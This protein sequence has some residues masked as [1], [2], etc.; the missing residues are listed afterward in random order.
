VRTKK[1]G[2]DVFQLKKK[3][4]AV[5]TV[6]KKGA[7]RVRAGRARSR[8]RSGVNRREN[9]IVK[10]L[11]GLSKKDSSPLRCVLWRYLETVKTGPERTGKRNFLESQRPGGGG[12]AEWVQVGE[13]SG[14]NRISGKRN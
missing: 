9:V 1:K 10:M 5:V 12:G 14:Q 2:G 8:L 7:C 11:T 4:E 3:V 13:D 6:L